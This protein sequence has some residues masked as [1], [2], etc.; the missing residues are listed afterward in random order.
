[1]RLPRLDCNLCWIPRAICILLLGQAGTRACRRRRVARVWSKKQRSFP[2]SKIYISYWKCSTGNRGRVFE[3]L[4][5]LSNVTGLFPSRCLGKRG[6]RRACPGSTVY[7]R[8]QQSRWIRLG[9]LRVGVTA[10][11]ACVRTFLYFDKKKMKLETGQ[12]Q[13]HDAAEAYL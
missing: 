12:L 4:L 2:L 5:L 13:N 10:D 11:L 3:Q 7:P 6:T 1:M 9:V 8:R